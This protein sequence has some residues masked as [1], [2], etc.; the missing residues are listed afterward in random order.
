MAEEPRSTSV[1]NGQGQ[2]TR[3]VVLA[4]S[5]GDALAVKE[6]QP[7]G[8]ADPGLI[9]RDASAVLSNGLRSVFAA[10][11]WFPIVQHD[12]YLAFAELSPVSYTH[13][14]LPT[15]LRV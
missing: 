6:T 9:A 4:P 10:R 7:P 13:L 1:V 5:D 8:A 15:I 2:W 14:T 3:V 12:P 11:D